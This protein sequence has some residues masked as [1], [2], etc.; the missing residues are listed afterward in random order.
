MVPDPIPKC[1]MTIAVGGVWW[2]NQR[3]LLAQKRYFWTSCRFFYFM[4][5]PG[6]SCINPT[7]YSTS[8]PIMGSICA[9]YCIARR[10][11]N[12]RNP[13]KIQEKGGFWGLTTV[14]RCGSL[15]L[16]SGTKWSHGVN[17][18]HTGVLRRIDHEIR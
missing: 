18:G 12:R 15:W 10:P 9:I 11:F 4:A 3:R 14:V 5:F 2:G 13:L 6:F 7:I 1:R 8:T 16:R 17:E